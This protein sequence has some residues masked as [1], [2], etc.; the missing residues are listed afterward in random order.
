[1]AQ[2]SEHQ[3]NQGIKTIC[4]LMS[5]RNPQD[6]KVGSA[7][8]AA[9]KKLTDQGKPLVKNWPAPRQSRLGSGEVLRIRCCSAGAIDACPIFVL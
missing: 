3:H 7:F 8:E 4:G 6:D 9:A 5:Y 1:M 2:P